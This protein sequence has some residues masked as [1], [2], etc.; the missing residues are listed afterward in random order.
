MK[1]YFLGTNGWFDSET[2]ETP[3]VLVETEKAYVIFDAGN[4]LRKID[5]FI[6]NEKPIYI[7]LS[8]FHIDHISG[9]HLLMKFNFKQG[10]TIAGQPG[11]IDIISKFVGKP[12]TAPI[13]LVN[14]KYPLK[15][16]ELQVGMNT[17]GPVEIEALPLLHADPCF[18]YSLYADS[19]KIT[20]CT[21]T[22][23]TK[24]IAILAKDSDL[25]MTECAWVTEQ[26]SSWP[27]LTPEGG[28]QAAAEANAKFLVLLHFD[29][30]NYPRLSDRQKAKMRAI[31]IFPN[32][33]VAIDDMLIEV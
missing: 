28:A 31:A 10:I 19:K 12:Y 7:L 18:G 27:H 1:I 26:Q 32:S 13:N 23:R 24:N 20:Y 25:L 2:G 9:L 14:S 22:G 6:K 15:I 21:D 33:D 30:V 8:H 11:T 3:C 16:A 5:R 17:L 29:P 4:S